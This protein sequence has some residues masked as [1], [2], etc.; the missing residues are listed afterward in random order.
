MSVDFNLEPVKVKSVKGV[1]L[2]EPGKDG[3]GACEDYSE[4][5]RRLQELYNRL[6]TAADELRANSRLK[7]TEYSTPV[8]GLL[9]LRYADYR[10]GLVEE[11]LCVWPHLQRLRGAA[12]ARRYEI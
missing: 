8:L 9:F 1:K 11:K 2:V 3:D 4:R 6:W 12:S 10:F 7:S 5:N